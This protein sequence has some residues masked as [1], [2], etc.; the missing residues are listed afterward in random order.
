MSQ[1]GLSPIIFL[2]IG[3]IV[4]ILAVAG[5][6]LYTQYF[7]KTPLKQ[8]DQKPTFDLRE[9]YQNPFQRTNQYKNPFGD[10]K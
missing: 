8:T 3:L 6:I 10:L 1:K 5:Y 2:L 9:S 4:I 7:S